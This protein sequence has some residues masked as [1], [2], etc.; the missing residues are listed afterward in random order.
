MNLSQIEKIFFSTTIIATNFGDQNSKKWFFRNNSPKNGPN[1][2][3]ISELNS[4]EQTTSMVWI[5]IKSDK[6]NFPTAIIATNFGDRNAK[7]WFFRNNSPQ[8]NRSLIFISE[9]NSVEQTT[10]MVWILIKSGKKN[11][12][13]ALTVN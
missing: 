3:F 7:K 10:S 13:T 6:K 4:V 2:I 12:S 11:F 5:L 1:S 9:L 8:K